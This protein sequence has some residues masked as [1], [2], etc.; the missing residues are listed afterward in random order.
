MV[1]FGKRKDQRVLPVLLSALEQSVAPDRAVEAAS[2][3]L[4]M[5]NE[6]ED[7]KGTDYAAALRTRF[8]LINQASDNRW[9]SQK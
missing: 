7:W 1:G 3:M 9:A 8:F 2:E 6:S 4:D 5:Q